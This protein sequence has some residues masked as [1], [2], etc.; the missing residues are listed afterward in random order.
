MAEY[1]PI[2]IED[3]PELTSLLS[4]DQMIL[5]TEESGKLMPYVVE[6]S[7]LGQYAL[8]VGALNELAEKVSRLEER[9]KEVEREFNNTYMTPAQ[10]AAQYATKTEFNTQIAKIEKTEQ[11][12][13]SLSSKAD[14][15]YLEYKTN[16]IKNKT[17]A[18]K[19]LLGS[20]KWKDPADSRL[21]IGY[22]YKRLMSQAALGTPE[23]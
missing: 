1:N 14:D 12:K 16:V 3:F 10:V 5:F 2:R 7:A 17:Q 22:G 23:E 13:A 11:F 15:V 19:K 20:D 6:L 21:K 4:T 18:Y 9:Y 8:S